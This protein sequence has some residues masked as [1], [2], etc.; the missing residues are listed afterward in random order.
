MYGFPISFLWFF[1]LH[2]PIR[3][4]NRLQQDDEGGH[5]AL[6]EF[7]VI[8]KSGIETRKTSGQS[9]TDCATLPPSLGHDD[10]PLF[11][12]CGSPRPTLQRRAG[13]LLCAQRHHVTFDVRPAAVL[14]PTFHQ[15]PSLLKQVCAPV[16]LFDTVRD[17][18]RKRPLDDLDL[19]ELGILPRLF[20]QR[21]HLVAFS[22]G[23]AAKFAPLL[24]QTATLLEQIGAPIGPL[25]GCPNNVAQGLFNY[26]RGVASA[27]VRPIREGAA[28]AMRYGVIGAQPMQYPQGFPCMHWAAPG[29]RENVLTVVN[30]RK[31]SQQLHGFA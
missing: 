11:R 27:L 18:V 14:R 4:N 13:L 10:E 30:P 2:H 5:V 23:P 8:N 25:Y 9:P 21:H 24:H 20:A 1:V 16:C 31:A 29:G 3:A 6:A 17:S 7:L 15:L 26:M 19:V 22:V 12:R 28:E